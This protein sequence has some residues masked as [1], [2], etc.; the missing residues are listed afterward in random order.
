MKLKAFSKREIEIDLC[1][2]YF[3]S[4]EVHPNQNGQAKV[5]H[6]LMDF[7]KSD[8]STIWFNNREITVSEKQVNHVRLIVY[9]NPAN[10]I[11]KINVNNGQ[12]INY[13]IYNLL[14]ELVL[15][16]SGETINTETLPKGIFTLCAEVDGKKIGFE[17][18]VKN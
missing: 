12:N 1:C 18:F 15:K 5:A 2:G 16:G 3:H 6:L 4:C 13:E 10:E 9:P 11:I 8:A 17:K 14:G 7:F